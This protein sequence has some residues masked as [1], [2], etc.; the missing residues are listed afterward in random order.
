MRKYTILIMT[1][2]FAFTCLNAKKV[3]GHEDF[4]FWEKLTNYSISNNGR[5]AACAVNPQEGDGVLTLY[6]T[7]KGKKIEIERGYSPSFTADSKWAIV[8]IKPFFAETR[9]A[10]IAKKKGYD[11]PQDSLAIINL[12]TGKV[13]KI[14]NV[15]SCKIGKDGGDW[16]AWLSC[17][18][19][20]IKPK[21]LKD[22]K[23]GRPLV[24]KNLSNGSSRIL[25][26]VDNYVF[27][28]DG[29]KL[30]LTLKKQ[31]N[32]SLSTDGAGV[33]IFPD[34]AFHLIDRDKNF[35]GIPVFNDAG[36]KLAYIASDDTIET[37]T[38]KASLYLVNDLQR[39]MLEVEEIKVN[40]SGKGKHYARP[41][42]SDVSE[43]IKMDEEWKK[44]MAA[45][46]DIELFLNQYSMP[47]FSENGNRLVVGVAPYVAPDDTTL[48]SFET[49]KLDIWRWD[50]PMTPPQELNRVERLRKLTYPVVIN[51]ADHKQILMT[52]NPLVRITSPDRWN[53]DW[54][55][56]ADPSANIISS[57]WDYQ[58]PVELYLKNVQTGE[59]KEIST[60]FN[61]SYSYS[62]DAKYVV[63]FEDREY[64]VY[65]LAT[66]EINK[67]GK[68]I[69]YLL[70]DDEADTP[71]KDSEPYGIAAWT[72]G[73]SRMLVY[74]HNDLWAVDPVGK[75]ES[76]CITAG[77][78]R[79]RDL[80][81]R[82]IDTDPDQRYISKND[83]LLFSLFNYSDKRNGLASSVYSGKALAPKIDFLDGYQFTQ[84]RKAKDANVYSWDQANFSTSPNVY[85]STDIEK[86]KSIRVTDTNPQMADYN[87]GTAQLFQWKAFNGKQSDGVLYLPEDFD[88]D[89]EYPM[90][91]YFYE[92][93][94]QD[95]YKH[96]D[97]E[98]SW[99]WINFPFY[100]S[101]GYVIFVPDIHYTD[102][103]P[104]ECAYNYVCS[105][106]DAVC[107]KYPNI[108]RKRIGIDGQSWGGY[109]TAYLVTRTDMFACAGSG[110]PVAN[111]T[112][113]FGGIRWGSGDSRQGQYEQGQSRIGRNLW[114]A[115][116]LYIANSPVFHANRVHTPLL[117]MHNDEDG[118]VPW[119]QGIEM[120]MAL[121]RLGKPVWM[122]QYNGEA[123][124]LVE[125]RNRKDITR[126]LQ[127]FFDHYLKG[128]PMPEWMENGIPAV[129]KGQ[130][131]GY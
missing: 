96:Y 78:G 94:S 88:P 115:T 69:P 27:S 122:L 57:Q 70:W 13:E 129:R 20:L 52:D 106:V 109:Q 2:L 93:Y 23:A 56:I 113:A 25:N 47:V 42:T 65:S 58:Y 90:L 26:W 76:V 30:A 112:S 36:T 67:V 60:V 8:K 61:G 6:D 110:A 33:V 17:D 29:T 127:Q 99:S 21:A 12:S 64:N 41:V 84:V 35:Y 44:K 10:K 97:M 75:S 117:I 123:H 83:R 66:G 50:A 51:L 102:G 45:Q 15:I 128:D 101:R 125:R 131:F 53:G 86:G 111:M 39:S 130:E 43:Q 3:L 54:A 5:W 118:A 80:R 31:K 100:V 120:F 28:K 74:D 19:T 63:W 49:P 107:D 11:L 24:M 9:K 87:W 16:V 48:V 72:S 92:T 119:Y 108:D 22:K 95:L 14:G 98:P 126:R 55:L 77:E 91:V 34:T 62:P 121:R 79:K 38:K 104:G 114:D 37:G 32:D 40:F 59:T 71:Q 46:K 116:E 81:L 103:I 89:K 105:G 7:S 124:N 85:V 82:L 4:D 1:F 68:D 18:T 73:D